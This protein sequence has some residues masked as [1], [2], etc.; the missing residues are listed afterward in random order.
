MIQFD[1]FSQCSALTYPNLELVVK[2]VYQQ[3]MA[4]QGGE[5]EFWLCSALQATEITL[6]TVSEQRDRERPPVYVKNDFWNI[7][8]KST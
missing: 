5:M 3:R 6:L 1:S 2:R 7:K 8:M 4:V